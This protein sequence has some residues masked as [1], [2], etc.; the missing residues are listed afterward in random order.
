MANLFTSQ[1]PT[2]LDNSDGA[3]GISVGTTVRFTADGTVTGVRFYATATVG[4]T[5][6]GALYQVTGPDDAPSGTL[7]ASK[8]LGTTP[9]GGA[10]NTIAF[11]AGDVVPVTTGILYRAVVFSGAGRYV[12]APNIH[13]SDII[14][15][16]IIGDANGDDPVGLGSLRQAVFTINAAL[17]YPSTVAGSSGSYFADVE[18]TVGAIPDVVVPTSLRLVA[19]PGAPTVAST[20][21]VSPASLSLAVRLGAPTVTTPAPAPTGGT[22]AGW[23][24]LLSAFQSAR[25]DAMQ[26]AE[27]DR[28]PLECPYHGWPLTRSERGLHCEYG[29]HVITPRSF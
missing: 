6:T 21:T 5:Y 8:V 7:L 12:F 4:G 2:S 23:N 17:A 18:Y 22:P 13:G 26:N 28:N 16:D 19:T 20:I 11:D 15:G 1:T 25:A 3:P 24:G 27:R 29:G 14:T 10:W 9:T